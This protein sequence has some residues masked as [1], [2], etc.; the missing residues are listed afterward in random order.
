MKLHEQ[1]QRFILLL[2]F[3]LL[4]PILTLGIIGTIAVRKMPHHTQNWELALSQ[5][6]GLHWNIQTVEFRSP[7]LVRLHHV[8]VL[9]ESAQYPLFQAKYVDICRMTNTPRAKTFPGIATPSNEQKH[10]GLTALAAPLIDGL[11]PA[12]SSDDWFWQISVPISVLDFK[13]YPGDNSALLVQNMLRKIFARINSLSE[14]PVQFV[15]EQVAV[16]SEYSIANS[17]NQVDLFQSVQGNLYR[18]PDGIRSDWAFQIRG[19]SDIA[20][21]HRERL[22]FA[23]ADQQGL[24]V[25][26]QSGSQAIPCDLAA[27]FCLPFKNFSGGSF[28]GKMSYAIPGNRAESATIRLEQA[29][30]QNFPLAPLA[31]SYTDFSIQGMV[32]NLV[33]QRAVF[34]AE[35]NYAEGHFSIQDGLIETALFHRCVDRF[36]LRVGPDTAAE[37]LQNTSMPAVPFTESA[38]H[39]RLQA[40]GLDFWAY[41]DWEDIFMYYQVGTNPVPSLWVRLPSNRRTVSYYEL[42]SIFA[43]D[44]APTVP[45]T[46]GLQPLLQHIPLR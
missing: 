17:P 8:Q 30:F 6:T 28:Q 9:D 20:G 31:G 2:V 12:F 39:F 15:F 24:T 38:V 44:S 23:F 22:S 42:M 11:L 13:D 33:I 26:F 35:G 3:Y 1:T 43:P 46:S 41:Q 29:V 14:V 10:I 25:S 19:I 5:K 16:R 34:G 32:T 4:G 37:S 40:E 21:E 36:L 45:L 18:M 27:V 7:K